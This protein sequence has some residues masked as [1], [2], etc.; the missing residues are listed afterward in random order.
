ML[1]TLAISIGVAAMPAAFA[2]TEGFIDTITV[3]AAKQRV[4]TTELAASVTLIDDDRIQAELA[5]TIQDLVRYEP[6]IDVSDQGSRFGFSGVTI[7][8]VGGNRVKVEVDGVATADAFSIGSFS[9]AGRDFVD[10]AGLKQVEIIRGPASSVFGSDALGGVLSF[11][12]KGPAD[13]LA[14]R[15]SSLDLN[16]GYNSVDGSQ[17]YGGSGA[18]RF[19]ELA[20]M[21][22]ITSRT[23]DERDIAAADPHDAQSLHTLLRLDWGDALAGG[24]NLSLERMNAQS[25]TEVDSQERLQDFTQAFGFPYVIDTAIVR[26]DDER[27]R[28]RVSVGQEWVAGVAGTDY[29]RWRAYQQ[30]SRTTQDTFEQRS[31]FIAGN[32]A[33][34]SRQRRFE[35][36]QGLVG[37]E[38]NAVNNISLA[39]LDH[40]L[41]YGLEY[42]VTDTEQIRFGTETGLLTG[43]TSNQVGP[44]LFPVRDFPISE[45]RRSGVY[46]EDRIALG[47]LTLIPGLR[48]DR[49]VLSPSQDAIFAA[50]NPGVIPV[51]YS[52]EELSPKFGML[53]QLRDD[54]QL[55]AQY[56]HGFRAPPVNDVNVGFTNLVFGYTTLPNPDLVSESSRGTELGVRWQGATGRVEFATFHTRYSDFIESFQVVGRDPVSS[57]LLFQSINVA[58]VEIEG[59][60]V[61][62]NWTPEKF[63]TGLSVSAS[64][65]YARGEDRQSGAPLNSVAPLNGVI[66]LDFDAPAGNWGVGVL[67]S[68]ARQQTHL[69]TSAGE[70]LS[71]AS[72]VVFDV[73]GYWRPSADTRV[74]FGIYN[75]GDRNYIAY[76]DVQGIDADTAN[77]AR[78]QRPGRQFSVALDWSF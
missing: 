12:T 1:K 35:F 34:V 20:A 25:D 21:L 16:A 3:E 19:G 13:V 9:N 6:G 24:L 33:E 36:E 15:N 55:Y 53:W 57:I 69:D 59:A 54:W 38:V 43:E 66:G 60:E 74:R 45:T 67:A 18:I 10:V 22:R 56:A 50:A 2:Q 8:G 28:L 31:S 32:A 4:A 64:A 46:L 51:E 77:T 70:L 44:D 29:L 52:D 63:P 68:G 65:A 42:E 72:Y 78:F 58:S 41:S 7:R 30:D 5:Q 37:A 14:G 26:G 17:V 61:R 76:T 73:T 75:F 48:W 39:G 40:Q 47:P 62:A 23:G 11:V 71:P 27:E 49:Y